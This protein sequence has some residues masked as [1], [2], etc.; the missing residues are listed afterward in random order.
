MGQVFFLFR[1]ALSNIEKYANASKVS[2][3]LDWA[4]DI[5][6]LLI[7]DNGCGFNLE[8]ISPGTHYGI[9]FM[10]ERIESINGNF[11]IQS[12]VGKG[13]A[14]KITIPSEQFDFT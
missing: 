7:E 14:I 11:S 10:K 8:D 4:K 5:F 3:E 6:E 13:T 2:V 12:M 9:K 1:E